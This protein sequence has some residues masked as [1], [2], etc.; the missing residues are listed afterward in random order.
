MGI[1]KALNENERKMCGRRKEDKISKEHS[2]LRE[3]LKEGSMAENRKT[4]EMSP[5]VEGVQQVIFS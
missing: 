4:Q 2:I 1:W 3:N 5:W